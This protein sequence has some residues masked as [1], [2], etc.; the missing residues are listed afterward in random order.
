[1]LPGGQPVSE[2]LG[3]EAPEALAGAQAG[4]VSALEQRAAMADLYE[5]QDLPT[6]VLGHLAAVLFATALWQGYNGL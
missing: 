1:M 6:G 4:E 5:A 2:R 3:G